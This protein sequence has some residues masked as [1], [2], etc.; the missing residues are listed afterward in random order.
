VA[1]RQRCLVAGKFIYPWNY[2]HHLT[3]PNN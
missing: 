2:H 1:G 3:S